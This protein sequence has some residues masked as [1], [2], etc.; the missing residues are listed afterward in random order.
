MQGITLGWIAKACGGKLVNAPANRP[1]L[2][3]C[4]DSRKIAK[5]DLFAALKGGRTD[6]HEF[7]S[8][9]AVA[10]AAAA[11]C[12]RA[13]KGAPAVLTRDPR[14]ALG[15]IAAA[16]RRR[17]RSLLVTAVTGSSGKTSTKE[18]MTR[19]LETRYAVLESF[20]N[21]NNDLGLPLT[22]A[23]LGAK[24][25]AAVLE[26]GMSAA[27]EI[28][29]L[30]EIAAPHIGVI[31]NIGEAHLGRFRNRT[32]LARAKGE[33]VEGLRPNGIAV[34]NADDPY[35]AK[36]ATKQKLT[37]GMAPRADVR[38]VSAGVRLSGT[39]LTL[40]CRGRRED[41]RMR[42]LGVHQAWNAAAAVAAGIA[43]GL[44]FSAAC[45]ALQGHKS[46]AAMRSQLLRVGPHYLLHD[47]YNSNPQS[48]AA[49]LA[50]QAELPC[51]GKRWFVAGSMLELGATSKE[52]HEQ[53]G[54]EAAISGVAG[55][56]AVGAEAADTARAAKAAGVPV[57]RH[58]TRTPGVAEALLG[59]L[60][61]AGDLILVK[62]SRGIELEKVVEKIRERF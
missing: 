42:V 18:M 30:T 38:V 3:L 49:A 25:T 22:L 50:L 43:A 17:F 21:L 37:F 61:P 24:H 5:G 8:A 2:G 44:S 53:L 57:V 16:Y 40:E 46:R 51:R 35:L 55:L 23:R 58:F 11:L 33:L 41:I 13:P 34:L 4:I 6:G 39:H 20:G 28:R 59:W 12:R 54:R 14:R 36:L 47:A 1:V 15:D 52:A 19:V 31:T 60:S 29:R 27:G 56:I 26:M 45:R 48:A 7:I 32:A 62:G 10:G 9:A